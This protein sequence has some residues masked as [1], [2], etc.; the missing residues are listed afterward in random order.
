MRF[1]TIA[2][3]AMA[4]TG[5]AAAH[6]HSHARLHDRRAAREAELKV[7]AELKAANN[8]QDRSVVGDVLLAVEDQV[9]VLAKGLASIG[10]NAVSSANAEVWIGSD[11]KW[12]NTYHNQA[13]DDC[14]LVVWGSA[15]SW[16]NAKA[17]LVTVSIPA[18]Q[19]KTLSFAD[20]ASGA[21]A[22]MY[23]DTELINGQISQT[24]GEY[25]FGEYGVVDVSREVNMQGHNMTI[26]TPNCV[27]DM[28]TCVFVCKDTSSISCWLEYE[29]KNCENGS[30]EG[31]NKGTYA[32]A[33]SGGCGNMGDSADLHTYVG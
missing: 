21:W 14:V 32:G 13:D 8:L 5:A 29:L 2:T 31:A 10:Q 9:K 24:W 4:A 22:V 11:G 20:G 28:E 17:P 33:D 19:N 23:N 6:Q 18:G 12:T 30:Q 15:G 26:Q 27:T 3:A 25:T 1:S 7:G 16:V